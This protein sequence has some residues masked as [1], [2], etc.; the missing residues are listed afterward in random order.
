MHSTSWRTV[1]VS[2][3]LTPIVQQYQKIFLEGNVCTGNSHQY[4]QIINIIATALVVKEKS[5]IIQ[6][7]DIPHIHTQCVP[8][9]YRHIQRHILT[10]LQNVACHIFFMSKVP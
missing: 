8:T 2:G 5:A 4:V 3:G 10:L 9:S 6:A 7:L 1:P